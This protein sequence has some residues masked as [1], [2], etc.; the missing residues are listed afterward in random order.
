MRVFIS[1]AWEDKPLALSLAQWPEFIDPWVDVRKL[2]GG[3]KLDPTI[4]TAI[5]DSHVFIV[6]ISRISLAKD[7]VAQEV[8]WAMARE[9]QKDRVFVL[10]VVIE[11]GIDLAASAPPFQQFAQRLFIDASDR[12]DIGTAKAR[13]AIEQTLFHWASDW[14]DRMEP[15]GDSNRRF[16]D[17]LERDLVEFQTRLYAVKAALAWP[18]AT[19]VKDDA[20]A[21]LVQV[22][23][24]YNVFTEAFI[25]RLVGMDAEI[26]WRFGGAAQKGFARLVTF[27]RNEVY[28]GAAFALNDVIESINAFDTVLSKDAAA[29]STADARRA[30]RMTALEPV[31]AELVER[32][33][34]YVDTLRP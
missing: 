11:A 23:D 20:V 33:A 9:A 14:L 34:D 13:T 10:P 12:S 18:L 27:I 17:T 30:T 25:P 7:W 8:N 26:R 3:E 5:E 1:H 31:M 24:A 16:V 21:H 32:T 2:L 22:K 15:K 28:H 29:L 4:I 19:L 6:L